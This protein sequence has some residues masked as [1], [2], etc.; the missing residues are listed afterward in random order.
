MRVM[1]VYC[2]VCEARAVIKK[3]ARK[4]KELSD[5]YCACTD[6]ECGHTFVLNLTFSHTLSPSAKT[7]DLM[8]QKLL[9]SLSAEQKQMTLVLLKAGL[10]A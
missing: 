2:P 9:N 1:K 5:L 3:T 8:V 7:G 4:H 10:A 6:V